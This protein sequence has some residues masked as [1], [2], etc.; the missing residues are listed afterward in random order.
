MWTLLAIGFGIVLFAIVYTLLHP[1]PRRPSVRNI[2]DYTSPDVGI[3][4]TSNPAHSHS[5]HSPHHDVHGDFGS[6]H[7]AGHDS[8]GHG[9]FD[10]GHGGFDGGHGGFDGGHG[11]FDGGGHH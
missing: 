11:G 1:E 10:S 2:P 3:V 7:H 5:S 9:G 4:D 6:S 8:G